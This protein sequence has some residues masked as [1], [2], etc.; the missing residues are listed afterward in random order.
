MRSHGS[1]WPGRLTLSTRTQ[2]QP[3]HPV[4]SNGLVVLQK[5]E[6]KARVTGWSMHHP[7]EHGHDRLQALYQLQWL[8]SR[9]KHGALVQA[10]QGHSSIR[11]TTA[12]A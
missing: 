5:I 11:W 12:P 2:A 9:I 4:S 6:Q 10:P 1:G 7:P 3:P 8:D